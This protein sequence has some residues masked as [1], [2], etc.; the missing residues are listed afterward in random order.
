MTL[1]LACLALVVLASVGGAALGAATQ[2]AQLGAAVAGWAGARWLGPTL[3]PVLQG[4]VPA[5]AAHPIASAIAFAACAAAAMIVLHALVGLAGLVGLGRAAR[6]GADRGLG[7]LFGGAQAAI[8][9]WV[10]LSALAAW[11]KPVQVGRLHVDPRGSD[12][13]AFAR[14]HD[15]LGVG[16]A[17]PHRPARR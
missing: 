13:V 7:A 12:L 9:V 8:V 6:G 14:E 4:R 10:G 17:S 16:N 2:L 15:A 3:A 1:D 5:F 11:G